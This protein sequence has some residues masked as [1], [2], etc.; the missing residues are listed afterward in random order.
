MQRAPSSMPSGR[1][2][3]SLLE[4]LTVVSVVGLIAALLLPG[5]QDARAAAR[6]TQCRNNLHQ[7]GVAYHLLAE[8]GEPEVQ[9]LPANWT[10]KLFRF[11]E[12][13]SAVYVCPDDDN[14][15]ST[16]GFGPPDSQGNL[17]VTSA[18]PPSL[19][20][21]AFQNDTKVRL[22]AERRNFVLP[23]PLQVDMIGSGRWPS[24]AVAGANPAGITVDVWLLHYDPVLPAAS[25]TSATAGVP[26]EILGAIC[27]TPRLI[28]SDPIVGQPGTSYTTHASRGFE[29]GQEYVTIADDIKSLSIENF[30]VTSAMEELRLIATPGLYSS[31]GMNKEVVSRPE[32]WSGMVLATDYGKTI[33]DEDNQGTDDG[34][35]WTAL[36]H[37]DAANVLYGDGSVGEIGARSPFYDPLQEHWRSRSK[38]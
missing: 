11:V 3:T 13:T 26:G 14:R 5:L 29:S 19:Q 30:Y 7:I 17:E 10:W 24:N 6:R 12:E 18:L 23:A 15:N 20:V 16:S 2:G 33:I 4:V 36:R 34:L 9:R 27:S 37:H 35:A 31:Y 1:G 28:A 25:V 32:V 21:G 22:F 8:V 38:R